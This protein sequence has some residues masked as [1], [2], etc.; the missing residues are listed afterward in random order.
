M[1]GVPIALGDYG[2]GLFFS[3]DGLLPQCNAIEVK[4]QLL[5]N[6]GDKTND[7]GVLCADLGSL[8]PCA[9]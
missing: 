4:D 6:C 3:V 7:G 2:N 1:N 9:E 5:Q 8:Y